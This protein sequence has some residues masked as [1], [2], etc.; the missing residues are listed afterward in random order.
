ME[1][2]TTISLPANAR[3]IKFFP[4]H[5]REMWIIC[6]KF[7]NGCFI[8]FLN[9]CLVFRNWSSCDRQYWFARKQIHSA[10]LHRRWRCTWNYSC[11]QSAWRLLCHGVANNC[12][13]IIQFTFFNRSDTGIVTVYSGHSCRDSST[14]Q[15]LFNVSN[16]VTQVSSI[17]FNS[18]AQLMA[19]CSNAKEN[20]LR[21]VHVASQT[22]FKNFPE[23]NGKVSNAN[24]LDFSP[25]GGYL[26]VGNDRGRLHVFSIH[27]FSDY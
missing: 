2:I 18:D 22:V 19:I 27:H 6:G 14:P 9:C 20:H 1:H 24:C 13:R 4:S 23:R 26:A 16:L 3:C 17:A 25:S 7:L 10:L 15:P 12:S 11:N 21:L 8:L 5:N